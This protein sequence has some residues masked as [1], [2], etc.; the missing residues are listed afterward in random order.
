VILVRRSSARGS[1]RNHWLDARF[2]FSFGDWRSPLGDRW[3]DLVA[4]NEDRV[5]P[6]G[7]FTEHPH[8]DVEVMSYPLSGAIE[9]RDS[10]GHVARMARGDVHL[11]RAGRGIRHSEMNASQVEPEHHLQWWIRPAVRG[12][13]PDYRRLRLAPG[14]LVD[15]A[16]LLAAPDGAEGALALAQDA[17]VFAI[18]IARQAWSPPVAPQR[19]V[20]AHVVA[21]QLRVGDTLLEA[22]DEVFAHDATLPAF[23]PAAGGGEL[24]LF[25]L[26]SGD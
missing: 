17:R 16:R 22:G 19:K 23:E 10:L 24:L 6:G 18:A 5:A 3:S 2:S 9:H 13:A 7:G 4:F 11:M 1:F 8:A 20:F 14:V 12:L 26:R 25:D 21:G 15:R